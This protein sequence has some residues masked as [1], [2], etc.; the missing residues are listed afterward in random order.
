[1]RE[2]DGNWI[3]CTGPGIIELLYVKPSAFLQLLAHFLAG[4]L[5]IP[6]ATG[7][8]FSSSFLEISKSS[9]RGSYWAQGKTHLK[10]AKA[11]T[12]GIATS[13]TIKTNILKLIL[14]RH[15]YV[16]VL[17]SDFLYFHS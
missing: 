9:R 14:E 4:W 12:K 1:M 7:F 16:G 13:L 15:G 10:P 11:H 8:P 6:L 5:C 3:M 17:A 2:A